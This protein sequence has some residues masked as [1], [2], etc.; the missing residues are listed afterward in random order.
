MSPSKGLFIEGN[1]TVHSLLGSSADEYYMVHFHS[2]EKHHQRLTSCPKYERFI[3]REGQDD[4]EA[5]IKA[6]NKKIGYAA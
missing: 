1:A 3:D 4:P 5:Y 6:F 2:D